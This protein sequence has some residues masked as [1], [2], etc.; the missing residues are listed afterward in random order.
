MIPAGLPGGRRMTSLVRLDHVSKEYREGDELRQVLR[1]VTTTF[2]A[3]E[4]VAIQGRSGSGK[5]TLLNL[6]AGIDSPSAGEI[7]FGDVSLRGLS[8]RERTLLRRDRIGLVFQFFNLIPTLSVLENV[9]LP[10]ELCGA[11]RREAS[12]RAAGLLER[13]GLADRRTDFPDRLSG[14]EQQRVAIARALVRSP[15]L[16]LA[17]EP[18]G[19]L[20]DQTG[21]SVMGLLVEM[22]REVGGTL[23]LVTHSS[24]VAGLADRVL[25]LEAGQL[26]A[27]PGA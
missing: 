12:A 8:E 2:E 23:L 14:G 22:T 5:T 4:L 3:A 21:R 11:P 6:V 13:V 27:G 19:N 7:H 17:D 9:R 24:Q 10:A 20:D 1:D 26:V 16:L 25:R 18:T 15:Q